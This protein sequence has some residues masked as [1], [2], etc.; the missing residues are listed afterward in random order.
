[1]EIDQNLLPFR[2]KGSCLKL[3]GQDYCRAALDAGRWWRCAYRD[4]V[5][6]L[7]LPPA[8]GCDPF[9]IEEGGGV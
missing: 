2:A 9:G 5:V 1:L 6:A 3:D 8:N 7:R 4:P